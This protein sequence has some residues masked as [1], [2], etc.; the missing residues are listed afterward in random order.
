MCTLRDW[1]ALVS[2]LL[3]P[4]VVGM[5]VVKLDLANWVKGISAVEAW[6]GKV[7]RDTRLG[8]VTKATATALS[9]TEADFDR[10]A[11]LLDWSA[12]AAEVRKWAA[13]NDAPNP[14]DMGPKNF[15]HFLFDI[16]LPGGQQMD[17]KWQGE[18][19]GRSL[20]YQ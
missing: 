5:A 19:S 18:G 6:G 12:V 4:A 17:L 2:A 15:R 11:P 13:R 1:A 9:S 3:W 16:G 14:S 20:V 8:E 10:I 7:T